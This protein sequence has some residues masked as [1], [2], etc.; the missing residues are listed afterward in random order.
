MKFKGTFVF[1]VLVMALVAYSYFFE[2]KKD[3]ETTEKK[4]KDSI[5]IPY[6]KD[7]ISEFEI[8]KKNLQGVD[9]TLLVKKEKQADGKDLWM[10][11]TPLSDL[12]DAAMIEDWL[13][14][15]IS[16][17]STDE[18]DGSSSEQG[19]KSE[20][21]EKSAI[22]WAS[23]GLD[24]PKAR[25]TLKKGDGGEKIVIAVSGR[26]NFEHS[27]FLRKNED[28]KV[29]VAASDWLSHVD[30]SAF[31]FRDKHIFRGVV[32][33]DIEGI[34]LGKNLQLQMK[35]G[36]WSSFV[37]GTE[38][39]LLDQNKV[40]EL[41]TSI[42]EMKGLEFISEN[43]PNLEQLTKFGLKQPSLKIE[44]HLKGGKIGFSEFG[45]STDKTWYAWSK[46]LEKV[47]RTDQ[48]QVDK[49]L[50]AKTED[51]REKPPES[52]PTESKAK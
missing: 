7:Q 39:W 16:E 49:I 29:L 15:L 41:L 30:K 3:I 38:K 28:S 52:K 51:L 12:G 47:F 37:V 14:S 6:L 11:K 27:S 44:L 17:K 48:S 31:D 13:G 19:E 23:Y 5:I 20:Q 9:E 32:A 21:S 35:E 46:N 45:Q 10:I 40:R 33:A 26:K 18:L 2:Y 42:S 1:S 36:R 25:L 4:E 24:K 34:T 50:K 22:N 8:T 43:K